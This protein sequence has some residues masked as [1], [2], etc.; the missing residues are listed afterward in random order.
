MRLHPTIRLILIILLLLGHAW[1]YRSFFVDDAFIT[2]RVVQQWTR[3]N[4]LVYNIG[5]RVEAYS[6]FLWVVLLAPFDLFSLNLV[7][8]SKMLG[9]VLGVLTVLLTYRFARRLPFP[10]LSPLLLAV[11]APFTA[12]MMGGLETNLFTLLLV[13]GGFRFVREEETGRGWLSGLL[14]GLLALTR[15]EGLLFAAVAGGFRLRRLYQERVR[16]TRQDW[17]RLAAG[18]ALIVPYYL[19]RYGY[20]GY[21]L[22]NTVYAKA[23]GLHPRPLLEGGL[24]LYQNFEAIGGFFFLA[25]PLLLLLAQSE[26]PLFANYLLL[27]LAAYAF[28]V[29]AG[30]G[31]WMPLQR[32]LVHILPFT[33]LLIHAGLARLWE[34][35]PG[36]W[37][38]VLLAG[39]V[40]GQLGYL[41]F[42]S[43]EYNFISGVRN[44][45]LIPDGGLI[46]EA[47]RRHVQPGDTIALV[48]AGIF[49]YLLP[50]D[51]RAVD[52]VGLA[53]E[54]IAHRPPQFPSGLF[55]RGDGFGKWDVDYVL[56]QQPK[57]VTVHLRGQTEDGVW[58]TDFTG[59]TL[60]LNDPRFQE[61]YELVSGGD[62]GGV[63]V[64]K[65]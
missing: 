51:A 14:F 30:G 1:L 10:E 54:H 58:Q 57:V 3:G 41:L 48:D 8:V 64:R 43:L 12:W 59:T 61:Q 56:A 19:W 33:Y 16:L 53:D 46:A 21:F 44:A 37:G 65:K 42:G 9:V 62:I 60:L 2:F 38:K 35:W 5:E 17:F 31:D 49:A 39:L 52:M 13:L 18:A 20:Y 15:P 23:M 34:I 7:L 63:F 11:S 29:F 32:F 27:N 26:R 24:Y 25:L 45:P 50:L 40:L 47:L 55:G 6:N 28:F 4:G 22:P 36:R